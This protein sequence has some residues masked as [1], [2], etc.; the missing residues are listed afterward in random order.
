MAEFILKDWYGKDQVFDKKTIYVQG[1]DGELM[2]FTHGA[3]NPVIEPLNVT[4][5]GTYKVPEGVNG[6]GPVTVNIPDPTKIL[7]R[8]ES[9]ITGFGFNSTYGYMAE[10][11]PSPFT[12]EVGKTYYVAWDGTTYEVTGQ[13]A[14]ALMPGAVYI[15]D[16]SIWGLTPAEAPFLIGY[17]NEGVAY[18]ALNDSA[19]SHIVGIWQKVEPEIKLQEKTITEN[20][21]YTADSG[22][23]GLGKVTVDVK[24]GGGSLPAGIYL[25]AIT[26]FPSKVM[27]NK[28]F[29][30]NGELYLFQKTSTSL[31]IYDLYK[32]VGD[33]LETIFSGKEI[34]S[35]T[36]VIGCNGA[37]HFCY[38]GY[39]Y[40]WNGATL[41]GNLG[42]KLSDG[43]SA[44][45]ESLVVLNNEL[46]SWYSNSKP[47]RKW[48]YATN[49]WSE[50]GGKK[51]GKPF[52]HN[53][54]I[55]GVN[56][57]NL[58]RFDLA[59]GTFTTV[60]TF[61]ISTNTW[62]VGADEC[63]YFT[64]GYSFNSNSMWY[65]YDIDND[66]ITTVGYILKADGSIY[67]YT[68]NGELR[69]ASTNNY[70]H[71]RVHIIESTE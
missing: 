36:S 50:V 60:K 33:T 49:T 16:G 31:D 28:F 10:E 37:I 8:E 54:T 71:A 1:T 45:V 68:H 69:C 23:D 27:A 30:M 43:T 7:L 62:F 29:D 61:D 66:V 22:F 34:F 38:S 64:K 21:E 17:V 39:H 18:S 44:T 9:Q 11:V 51:C 70:T 67:F 26:P 12:L 47:Y 13:D 59:S 35:G 48:N 5:N 55:Y 32:V 56:E 25:E 2:P 4:E 20:G 24:G 6:F 15:G 57:T 58:N 19:A 41:T 14:S 53:G 3:G 52:V 40:I 42:N 63:L 46:Y 65:K